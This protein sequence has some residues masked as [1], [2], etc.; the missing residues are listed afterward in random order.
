MV[1]AHANGFPIGSYQPVLDRLTEA[2]HVTGWEARPL[3]QGTDP[4]EISGWDHLAGD[5][6]AEIE[7]RFD[8]PVIGVGHS[9][10]GVLNLL[11]AVSRPDLFRALVLLDPVVLTGFRSVVWRL[12]KRLGTTDRLPLISRTLRRRDRWPDR[13]TAQRD[14]AGRSAF[15]G[16]TDEAFDAYVESGLKEDNEFGG[17]R[18][19]YP[20]AWEARIFEMAPH[21]LWPG[22][23]K[24][25][26][27]L[28]VLRGE[29]SDT[30]T[31]GAARKIERKAQN[32]VCR[33]VEGTGHMLPMQRPDLV[34][35]MIEDWV[36]E[37]SPRN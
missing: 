35:R 28:L 25:L 33:I 30:L 15:G 11:A 13:E 21:D 20:K 32:G 23:T 22:I 5:L 24:L 14:W 9:L 6:R 34:A 1:F 29:H 7:T 16:W 26:S 10:G 19:R 37:S 17:I 18:L 3:I 27:P 8:T 31:I 12:M 36:G 2:F 4:Q